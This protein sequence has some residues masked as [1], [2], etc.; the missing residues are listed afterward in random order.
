MFCASTCVVSSADASTLTNRTASVSGEP[1]QEPVVSSKSGLVYEK[2]LILKHIADGG[3]EPDG[4]PL[5]EGDLITIKS[6]PA[7]VRPRAPTLNSVPSLLALL[8]SEWDAGMLETHTLRTQHKQ[9]R[10]ELSNALYENDAAK[11]VIARLARERDAARAA[12]QEISSVAPIERNHVDG[13]KEET[14]T[15]DVD[16]VDT[17][18]AV[19]GKENAEKLDATAAMLSKTRKKRKPPV[20]TA[21]VDDIHSFSTQ[22]EIPSLH[23]TTN[24]GISCLDLLSL[25]A[26]S[27]SAEDS[28]SAA[29]SNW[30]LTGGNDGTVL[31]SDWKTGSQVASAKAHGTKKVTAVQ[32]VDQGLHQ[33]SA[34]V[35]GSHDHT[36]KLWKLKEDGDGW[37]LGKAAHVI[38][39]HTGDISGLAIHPSGE[40]VVSGSLD[41]TWAFSDL[42]KGVQISRHAHDE[43]E[44]YSSVAVHPDG[45]IVG[46]G[47]TDST[48]RIWELKTAKNVA[49]LRDQQLLGKIS[50]MSFSENGYYFAT[51]AAD[52]S[53]VK[54]WDLRKLENFHTIDLSGMAGSSEYS[55]K[56][57]VSKVAFDYGAGYLGVACADQISIFRNKQWDELIKFAPSGASA[58]V[59]FKF[60]S[61]SKWIASASGTERKVVV[62]GV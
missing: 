59:D 30:V 37:A 4:T 6:V 9:L 19:G 50:S 54:L 28:S 43:K 36:V 58:V 38:K 44:A 32:W 49:T 15:M 53:I 52:S 10:L 25:P 60:G 51:A 11:R 46:T 35:T 20:G 29:K 22:G 61:Y 42:E 18:E 47:T 31:V 62:T 7:T 57:G 56:K 16:A 5:T 39:G 41:S 13:E 48:V 2:R 1:P 34:F 26:F 27:A 12:L 45:L 55:G 17:L 14:Q 24:A 21:S 23:S 3:S 40:F 8:Q 33:G